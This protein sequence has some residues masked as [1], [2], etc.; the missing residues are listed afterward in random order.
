MISHF[1]KT[2]P[3]DSIKIKISKYSNFINKGEIVYHCES[4]EFF[5]LFSKKCKCSKYKSMLQI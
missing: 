4:D 5:N 3:K 1:N 2:M